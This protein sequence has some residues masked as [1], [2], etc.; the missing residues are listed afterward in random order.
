MT[1]QEKASVLDRAAAAE[2]AY[3]LDR[4][5]AVEKAMV[6]DRATAAEKGAMLDRATAAEIS[7][8]LCSPPYLCCALPCDPMVH[9]ATSTN[10]DGE[11][12]FRWTSS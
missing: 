3:A 9:G 11:C 10:V 6:L 12:F 1:V 5:T 2:K 8:C 4:A 7:C